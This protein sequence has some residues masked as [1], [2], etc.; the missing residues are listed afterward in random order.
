MPNFDPSTS[1]FAGMSTEALQAALTSA[2]MALIALNSGEKE[3]EVQVTGGGQ[4]R[5]VKFVPAQ[6]GNLTVLIRQLQAQLGIIPEPRQ[7]VRISYS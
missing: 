1:I 4:H 5:M 7:R 3:A 6:I 2:Q